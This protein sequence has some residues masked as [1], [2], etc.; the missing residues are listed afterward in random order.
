MS[1]RIAPRLSKLLRNDIAGNGTRYNL[2]DATLGK[3]AGDEARALLA[4]ARDLER[5]RY[6]GD[7]RTLRVLRRLDRASGGKP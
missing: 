5:Y 4:V 6:M 3:A 2:F 1:K 7:A